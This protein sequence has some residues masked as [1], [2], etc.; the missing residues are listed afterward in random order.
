MSRR[1]WVVG[2]LV[3]VTALAA[4]LVAGMAASSHST[5]KNAGF[6]A[7]KAGSE[8]EV[9]K[10]GIAN[11][12]PDSTYEAQQAAQ[13]LPGR[14][15]SGRGDAN[16]QATYN[17]FKKHGKTVG[18]G[19]RSARARRNTQPCSISS[20]QAASRTRLPA[21]SRR[22]RSAAARSTTSAC[23]TSVQPAAACGSP[24][25]PPT[26]RERALAVQ[27]RLV[28]HERDRL[29][30][31]RSE[32]SDRQHRLR[33]HRRGNASGDSEAGLGIYKSTNG[34]D[35][36]TLVPGVTSLGTEQF[37]GV[38]QGREPARRPH[39][40][41]PRRQL[42]HWR[43]GRLQYP[44][45][46]SCAVRGVYRQTGATFTR[47]FTSALLRCRDAGNE[48]AVDPNNSNVL[49]AASFSKACG[50]RSTTGPR[51]R[52]SRQR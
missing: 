33:G 32:R 40:R 28:R 25:G 21:A 42:G 34:G 51:G 8:S 1:F 26:V 45:L 3:A 29:A 7:A 49:Y 4:A 52:R 37:N 22:W 36:W 11:E 16:A 39:Q 35:T 24:T 10:A 2:G 17:S 46:Q 27:V 30:A 38:R 14:L 41:H 48:V 20:S 9:D 13:R 5:A 15:D 6:V 23:S 47:I 43:G 19:Y 18:R 12:G 50:A 44:D 31:R